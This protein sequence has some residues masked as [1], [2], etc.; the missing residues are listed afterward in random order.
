MTRIRIQ[1]NQIN[2]QRNQ[3]KTITYIFEQLKQFW[4][5]NQQYNLP[6]VVFLPP[7]PSDSRTITI[8]ISQDQLQALKRKITTTVHPIG[9]YLRIKSY[10]ESPANLYTIFTRGDQCNFRTC[11]VKNKNVLQP[12]SL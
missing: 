8:Y 11:Q 10:Q 9:P 4:K 2:K 6:F 7:E 3:G 12:Q 5:M 1:E